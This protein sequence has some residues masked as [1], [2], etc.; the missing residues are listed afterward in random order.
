M[1]IHREHLRAGDTV[2]VKLASAR[3]P[4]E[5]KIL[6]FSGRDVLIDPIPSWPTWHRCRVSDIEERLDPP[7]YGKRIGRR[8]AVAA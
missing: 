4:F 5:A 6:G 8:E 1:N 2:L 3:S 7:P